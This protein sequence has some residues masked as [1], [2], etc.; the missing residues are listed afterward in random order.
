MKTADTITPDQIRM[1]RCGT[2]VGSQDERKRTMRAHCDAAL[3][4]ERAA[5]EHLTTIWNRR[6]AARL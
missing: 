4:G 3:R 2:F 1:I 5:L 6:S